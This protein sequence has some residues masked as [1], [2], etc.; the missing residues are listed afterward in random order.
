MSASIYS[1]G[2]LLAYGVEFLLGQKGLQFIE[3]YA[4]KQRIPLAKKYAKE[5]AYLSIRRR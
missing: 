4:K 1:R 5:F 3:E 2:L